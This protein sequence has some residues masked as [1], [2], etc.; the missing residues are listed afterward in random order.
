MVLSSPL[1]ARLALILALASPAAALALAED[2]SGLKAAKQAQP[3]LRLTAALD[4]AGM[5]YSVL[6]S[7]DLQVRVGLAEERSQTVMLRS[8]THAY[9]SEEWREVYSIAH[10]LA[11]NAPLDSELGRRL[12][13]ANDTLVMGAWSVANDQVTL[14][15]RLPARSSPL[16]LVEAID[17]VAEVAD[18]LEREL[19]PEG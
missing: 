14:I 12:L 19:T 13:A 8:Q 11:E 2:E 5:A 4:A 10:S 15:V 3:D 17:F 16:R 6:D 1:R 7:G 18:G 9:R